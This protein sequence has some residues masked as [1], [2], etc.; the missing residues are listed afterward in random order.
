MMSEIFDVIDE[1]LTKS[2]AYDDDGCVDWE[3]LGCTLMG[4]NNGTHACFG[5]RKFSVEYSITEL[6]GALDLWFKLAEGGE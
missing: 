6:L 3:D 1:E 4:I 5:G 2:H